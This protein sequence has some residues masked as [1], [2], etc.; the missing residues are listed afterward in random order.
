M[1]HKPAGKIRKY[2]EGWGLANI[3]AVTHQRHDNQ[4]LL[5]VADPCPDSDV[6]YIM[7]HRA[8]LNTDHTT[9]QEKCIDK[10]VGI[11]SDF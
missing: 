8:V 9:N 5:N 2:S 11:T 7:Q 4:R 6:Q 1:P 10:N 3:C